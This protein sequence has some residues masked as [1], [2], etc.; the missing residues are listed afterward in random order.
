MHDVSVPTFSLPLTLLP[1]LGMP[2]PS[3]LHPITFD[4]ADTPSTSP[5]NTSLPFPPQP[6]LSSPAPTCTSSKS[7]SSSASLYNLYFLAS[8]PALG[9]NTYFITLNPRSLPC[10]AQPEI[11]TDRPLYSPTVLSALMTRQRD[12]LSAYMKNP[13]NP[14]FPNL[15]LVKDEQGNTMDDIDFTFA[16]VIGPS[17]WEPTGYVSRSLNFISATPSFLLSLFFTSFPFS[18]WSLSSVRHTS[19]SLPLFC[20]HSSI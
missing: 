1:L 2:V 17:K 20:T 14:S 9:M 7:P 4:E 16:D 15:P 13:T 3:E 11:T 19:L 6:N 10:C 5:V 12:R 8:A 18:S